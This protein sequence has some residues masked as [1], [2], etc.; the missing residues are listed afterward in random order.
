MLKKNYPEIALALAAAIGGAFLYFREDTMILG[1]PIPH[2][3]GLILVFC[4]VLWI[5]YALF[6]NR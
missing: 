3:T 2:Y 4:G 1:Y 6:A 5:F